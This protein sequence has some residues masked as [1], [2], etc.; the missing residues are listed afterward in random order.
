[1]DPT[2]IAQVLAP[3]RRSSLLLRAHPAERKKPV[4]FQEEAR[5]ERLANL[6]RISYLLVWMVVAGFYVSGNDPA[7][8]RINLGYGAAWL[9]VAL[10]YHG[11]LARYPYSGFLK[12]ASTSFDVLVST[13]LL[14][15]YASAAGPAYA[16]KMPIFLNYF[17]SLGLA[18]LRFQRG[19]ALYATGIATVS[20]LSLWLWMHRVHGIDYGDSEAH[21]ASASVHANFVADKAVYLLVFGILL[22][23]AASNARRLVRLRVEEGD[24]AA[25]ESERALMAAGLAHEIK[26]PLGGI[27]GAAQILRDEG[28]GDA[29]F[30]GIIL[31]EASRLAG[32]V[33]GFLRYARPYPVDRVEIDPVEVVREFCLGESSLLPEATR[34]LLVE[35][36]PRRIRTDPEALR[37]ILLNLVQN[38]ECHGVSGSPVRIRLSGGEDAFVVAVED[39]GAGVP[40]AR[41]ESL[42]EPFGTTEGRGNGLGLAMS[43]RIARALGGELSYEPLSPGSRFVLT[44][45]GNA[46]EGS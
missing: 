24:R 20:Y 7:Y 6:I 12:Y 37:Q 8:N 40:P 29:R 13:M 45:P 10:A 39:D 44:L 30:T 35:D 15:A 3:S 38:A 22:I 31:S 11:V 34:E 9:A 18:A 1:M 23:A 17:C 36:P 19:L 5:A 33:E 42:F 25:R 32:V 21:A 27:Y 46:P 28:R 2:P 43:R 41:R 14:A 16:L 26:N 4:I